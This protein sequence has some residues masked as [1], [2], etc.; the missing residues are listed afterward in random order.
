MLGDF[1]DPASVPDL[2]A[3]LDRPP[4]PQYYSDDQPSGSTQYNAIFDA[5]RKI[6]APD[7]ADK[8]RA[9]WAGG[10]GA[11][12]RAEEG[13]EGRAAAGSGRGRPRQLDDADPRD[14]RVS[15]RRA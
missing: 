2:L 14:R 11:G 7:G 5:L 9:M 12:A 13:Q 15:V 3:A 4:L 8:V 10:P 1:Y 6:G